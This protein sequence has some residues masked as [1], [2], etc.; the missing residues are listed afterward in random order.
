MIEE[1]EKKI[2]FDLYAVEDGKRTVAVRKQTELSL[3]TPKDLLDLQIKIDKLIEIQQ[4]WL[5]ES[6]IRHSTKERVVQLSEPEFHQIWQTVAWWT[7]N[8]YHTS[9]YPD[10]E[11]FLQKPTRPTPEICAM[12]NH[13][14]KLIDPAK[15]RDPSPELLDK[16][17]KL[18]DKEIDSLK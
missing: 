14:K 12:Q 4:A 15:F 3:I 10:L 17:Q 16:I 7:I 1:E 11:L 13:W 9:L 18:R 5:G 2:K 8:I 6:A